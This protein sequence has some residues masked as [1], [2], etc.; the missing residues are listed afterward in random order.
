MNDENIKYV[1]NNKERGLITAVS[2]VFVSIWSV[3]LDTMIYSVIYN[4]D[5][6]VRTFGASGNFSNQYL[7]ML[8]N[9]HIEDRESFVQSFEPG[10][11]YETL[12]NQEKNVEAEFRLKARDGLYHW[13]AINIIP[14]T[15]STKNGMEVVVLIKTIDKQKQAELTLK[16]ALNQAE[17]T[18]LQKLEFLSHMS[19]EIR[20]RMNVITGMSEIA[21]LEPDVDSS[22]KN[23]I[24]KIQSS[25]YSLVELINDSFDM[26]SLEN[27]TVEVERKPMSIRMLIASL[28]DIF[29]E[30]AKSKRINLIFNTNSLSYDTYV[31]DENRILQILKNIITNAIKY[32]NVGG[33]VEITIEEKD[34]NGN[35][36]YL[37]YRVSDNGIGMSD[38]YQRRNLFKLYKQERLG[39]NSDV[40]GVGLGLPI[41][42]NLVDLLGGNISVKSKINV[43]TAVEIV[44]PHTMCDKVQLPRKKEHNT[45]NDYDFSGKKVLIVE[46]NSTNL[47]IIVAFLNKVNF[48]IDTA[49]DGEEALLKYRLSKDYYYDLILMDIQMPKKN[50]LIAAKEIREMRRKDATDIPIV[51]MTANVLREDI[52]NVYA[53]GM[54]G[55]IPK[56]IAMEELYRTIAKYVE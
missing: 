34:K 31:G 27:G 35:N 55:H 50:G 20:T 37:L 10:N 52:S 42:K 17:Y 9:I 54:N 41:A 23:C 45:I 48:T 3:N 25:A 4:N 40:L 56:P 47:E 26:T 8:D 22:I 15:G 38:D 7:G 29:R 2:N 33:Q 11:I 36:I 43:G 51:A 44:L 53:S 32:N 16:T 18:N 13:V 49:I 19:H 14:D 5:D 28:N 12:Q 6:I 1:V 39:G 21:L 46:D 24:L 30:E